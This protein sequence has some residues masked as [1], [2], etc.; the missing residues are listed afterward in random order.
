MPATL[1]NPLLIASAWM[2]LLLIWS[3]CN[4]WAVLT[5]ERAVSES[6][7]QLPEEPN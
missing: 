2:P 1:A 5:P 7:Q 4:A 3:I 6:L